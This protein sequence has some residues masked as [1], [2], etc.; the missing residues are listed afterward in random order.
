MK[1]ARGFIQIVMA[2]IFALAIG[3][4]A[5][6]A[7]QKYSA[8]S[9]ESSDQKPVIAT[10]SPSPSASAKP[11]ETANWKTYESKKYKTSF[12]YPSQLLF[13]DFDYGAKLSIHFFDN[14]SD[15][16]KYESDCGVQPHMGC[17]SDLLNIN[18]K[19]YQIL[20]GKTLIN[21]IKTDKNNASYLATMEPITIEGLNGFNLKQII[22]RPEFYQDE[23]TGDAYLQKGQEIIKVSASSWKNAHINADLFEQILS[24]FK[25]TD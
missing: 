19:T 1:P 13:S 9:P 24:T 25:F 8:K 22:Q 3:A 4:S 2:V 7:Y 14:D 21:F 15:L 18:V 20:Q 11:D 23:F 12:K 6:F 17:Y 10:T 16:Q 5:M